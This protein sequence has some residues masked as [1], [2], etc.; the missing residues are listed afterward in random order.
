MEPTITVKDISPVE[1]QIE[2]TVPAEMVSTEIDSFYSD[3]RKSVKIKGFR[4]GKV[5]RQI[6]TQY[7]GKQVENQV[8][9]KIIADTYERLLKEKDLRPVSQPIIDNNKL[10]GGKDFSFTARVE[11]QPEIS[12]SGGYLDI[13][14]EQEKVAVTDEDVNRY[15]EE[16]RNF[17]AQ[18]TEVEPDRPIQQ[19]DFVLL[20]YKGSINGVP[21]ASGE[22]KDRLIEIKPDSLL[23]GFTNQLVGLR[24]GAARDIQVEVPE[25]YQDKELAGKTVVL[26]VAIKKIKEKVTPALDDSF[27]RDMGEFETLAELKDHLQKELTAREEQ[28]V[29]NL[30]HNALVE[31]ILERNQF[32]VPASLVEKQ[33]AYL[34][35]D[36]RMRMRRQGLNIDSSAMIDRELKESYRPIAE[37]QVKRSF[38]L[39]AIAKAEGIDV[40]AAEIKEQL[41]NIAAMTG[42]SLSD[43][44]SAG[45][46]EA[47]SH[48]RSRILE[49]KTLEHL[50]GKAQIVLV[51][52]KKAASQ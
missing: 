36:A 31:K 2:V 40:T 39:D 28:R 38:L 5:P 37:F 25:D 29:R 9:T 17:H 51:D 14:V 4:Q 3:L 50:A 42:Q 48:L 26:E 30:L 47:K 16:L 27:A 41:Q 7:Y 22:A 43:L 45:E 32:E 21:L 19:G 18:L 8:V 23:P 11:V 12:L 13:T 24:T 10:E 20:D 46:E 35:N 44:Q 52:A 34:I 49:E 15:L 1:K 33:V 6:L